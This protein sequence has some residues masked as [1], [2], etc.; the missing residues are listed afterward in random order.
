MDTM[1]RLD[2][3]N[4]DDDD[5]DNDNATTTTAMA[6]TQQRRKGQRQLALKNIIVGF[7]Q[8]IR[9]KKWCVIT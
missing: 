8:T 1:D 2:N 4:N 5:N 6:T 3:N 9:N 7:N